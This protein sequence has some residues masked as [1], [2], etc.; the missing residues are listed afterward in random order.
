MGHL[1][2][3]AAALLITAPAVA[4]GVAPA[5]ADCMGPTISY[6]PGDV[7]RGQLVE[8]A[9]TG[10]GDNCYDTGPPPA[11]QGVLG[12][13][14]D[15]I[16]VVVTQGGT[17]EV[18]A[19][20]SADVDYEFAVEVPMPEW[21]EPGDAW[22]SAQG[23]WGEAYD[24]TGQPFVVVD[25][26]PLDAPSTPVAFGPDELAPVLPDEVPP[27]DAADEA[28]RD[29]SEASGG[30]RPSAAA[31]VAAVMACVAI[32]VVVLLRPRTAVTTTSGDGKGQVRGR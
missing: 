7:Q 1:R 12:H 9:G 25:G 30:F 5:G 28:R 4:L 19:V 27:D 10:W 18:V 16:E 23:P 2:R 22:I 6:E 32:G 11:G 20:G 29:S 17:D 24:Q 26:E 21:L 14:V 3:A 15:H 31:V 13:P 8:V